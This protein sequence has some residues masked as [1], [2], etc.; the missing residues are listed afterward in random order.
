MYGR[1]PKKIKRQRRGRSWGEERKPRQLKAGIV[2]GKP[3]SVYVSKST[4]DQL[5]GSLGQVVPGQGIQA[6]EGAVHDIRGG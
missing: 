6:D 4:R 5:L 1:E 2:N 3:S